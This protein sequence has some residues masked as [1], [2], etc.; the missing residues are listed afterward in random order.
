MS[1]EHGKRVARAELV[2]AAL[3]LAATVMEAGLTDEREAEVIASL[4]LAAATYVSLINVCDHAWVDIDKTMRVFV[5]VSR[6]QHRL[7]ETGQ[8]CEK[9]GRVN[10]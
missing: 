8:M 5:P 3:V 10:E 1:S 2:Q 4:D 6:T 7:I 9:C